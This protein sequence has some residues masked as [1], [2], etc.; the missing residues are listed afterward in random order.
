MSSVRT[1]DDAGERVELVVP[2][3]PLA[4]RIE[5]LTE[6]PVVVLERAPVVVRL[7]RS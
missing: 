5:A 1:G 6:P 3:R 4:I 2:A 7:H